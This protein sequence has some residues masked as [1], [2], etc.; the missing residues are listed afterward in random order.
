MPRH[1]TVIGL[2]VFALFGSVAQ[3]TDVPTKDA[4][5]LK[6]PPGLSRFT[7]SA[8]F[9]N[10][11]ADYDEIKAPAAVVK[12]ADEAQTKLTA[13]QFAQ[14]SGQRWRL[15]Y[16]IPPNRS[17][18]EVVRNYQQQL[19]PK[20]FA[21]LYECSGDDCGAAVGSYTGGSTDSFF[22]LLYPR[23]EYAKWTDA[24]A[25]SCAGGNLMTDVLYTVLKND[26]T[27]ELVALATHRPGI[28]SVYC[29]EEEWKKHLFATVV[30]VK[31]KLMET[32]MKLE[33]SALEK[34]M[35][36]T[37][38]VAIYGILFDTASATIKP[39]S[40]PSLDEIAKLLKK[41]TKLNLHIV[42][43][44]DGEGTLASNFDLSKRRAEA[45]RAALI[46]DYGIAGTRLTGNG[47]ASL[48]P[49]ALNTTDEGRAKNRR[50][51]LV[52]F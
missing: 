22:N 36:E 33:A 16:A 51:E 24:N 47:V 41:E 4:K 18:I 52:P 3:A 37:G 2:I 14:A 1:L 13:A 49:V 44:T 19:L 5:G 39:E 31:P 11:F 8:L 12:Y 25:V 17:P 34:A 32:N 15:M 50:V 43:H 26:K 42:G 9:L 40:K 27:G 45:V 6:D 46:K 20:G 30:Y 38:K 10:E 28:V 48:A 23:T 21:T 7:G 35:G 29:P